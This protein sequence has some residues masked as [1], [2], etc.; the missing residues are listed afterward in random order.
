MRH[1]QK[2]I[3]V[4]NGGAIEWHVVRPIGIG[5]GG[6]QKM[7]TRNRGHFAIFGGDFHLIRADEPG[8]TAHGFDMISVELML[9][10]IHLIIE[11]LVQ[12]HLEIIGAN[13]IFHAI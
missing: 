4:Q 3:A 11:C 10:H 2:L 7:R 13:L 6:N 9:Q 8:Q 5:A 1:F 12:A